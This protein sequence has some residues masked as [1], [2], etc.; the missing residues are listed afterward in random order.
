M[1]ILFVHNRYQQAGGEDSV[2]QA[3][4]E[5][6]RSRGHQ[7]TLFEENNDGIVGLINAASTAVESVYSFP[8]ARA[9][10]H[11][12]DSFRP[13]IVHVHNFFPR[14]SPSVH[15]ACSD[16]KVPVVQTLHN[17]RLLCPSATFMRNGAVCEDC[18]GKAIPL[19]AV[20]NSCYH[21]SKLATAAVANMLAI[22]RGLHTWSRKV[23]RFIALTDF[24]RNKFIAG[25]LPGDRIVI[26][27]NFVNLDNGVGAGAGGYALFVGRLSE[28]KG[29]ATLLEAWKRIHGHVRLKI[30]GD[31]PLAPLVRAAVS[32]TPGVEWLGACTR[33]EVSRLMADAAFLVFPSIWYETFGMSIIEGLSAGLPVLASRLGAMAELISDGQTGRLFAAG[34][35]DDLAAAIDWAL[36][37]P[38]ALKSMRLKARREFEEK[39]TAESNYVQLIEIYQDA[40]EA[41]VASQQVKDYALQN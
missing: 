38:E 17:Y 27:P 16:K 7:V 26:K 8:A 3:E 15:Y 32:T 9:V 12:I 41:E 29:I 22:H 13:D 24:A 10:G 34:S 18:L 14:I 5:L 35:S 4:I 40:M 23:S 2:V 11:R 20:K 36:A 25:G 1:R 31:G 33:G 6:L 19:P 21:S 30:A 39:Y 28:E 37:N